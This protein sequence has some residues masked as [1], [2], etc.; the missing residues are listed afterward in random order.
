MNYCPY[1]MYPAEDNYCSNCGKKLE[2]TAKADQLEAGAVLPVNGGWRNYQVGS[3]L[4]QGRYGITYIAVLQETGQRVA[5]KEY[6]PADDA[7]RNGDRSVQA[8]PGQEA[9]FRKG[10][11]GFLRE[12]KLLAGMKDLA[13]MVKALDF[14]QHNGTA[15]LAMEFLDGISL[16]DK[17]EQ[18]GPI[19]AEQVLERFH[20][21]LLELETV[22]N[23]GIIHRDIAPDNI[24]WMPDGTLRLM[25][26]GCAR[27]TQAQALTV[28]LKPRFA[29]VEQYSSMSQGPWT[30]VYGIAATIYY[31]ITGRVPEDAIERL[32]NPTGMP[33]PRQLGFQITEDQEKAI[34]WGLTVQP[35]YRPQSANEFT[36]QLYLESLGTALKNPLQKIRSL[37]K[38]R[39]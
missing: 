38:K 21:L 15:Y 7:M 35:K 17:V 32:E 19:P 18:E 24:M 10:M 16:K 27:S 14:F 9:A 3:V 37:W 36:E 34:M 6:F 12:A 23:G 29:P 11:D 25:D 39:S 33:T 8:R 28:M 22:H 26:F 5:V 13:T 20:P 31:C 30:D 2:Y 4:G 1:C